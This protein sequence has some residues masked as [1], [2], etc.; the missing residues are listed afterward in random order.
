MVL[1]RE[2][3]IEISSDGKVSI[4]VKGV[5]GKECLEFSRFLEETL[6]EVVEREFTSEYYMEETP[7]TDQVK[8]R[9]QQ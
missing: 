8:R 7:V 3:E 1:K 6:G 9:Y 2:L 4:Q 5:G